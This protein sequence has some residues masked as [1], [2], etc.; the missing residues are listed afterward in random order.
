[1]LTNN[2]AS[3]QKVIFHRLNNLQQGKKQLKRIAKTRYTL[4]LHAL[5]RQKNEKRK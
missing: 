4:F 1:M 5:V 3:T 2:D